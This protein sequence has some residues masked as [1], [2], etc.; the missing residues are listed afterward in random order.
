VGDASRELADGSSK[1]S[2]AVEET[3]S[4]LEEM[5][6]MTAQNAE[7]ASHANKLMMETKQ[8]VEQANQS[9]QSVTASMKEISNASEQTQKIIKTID[10]VAFQTNLLAL[11]AAVE[12]ARAGEA[13]A[14]FAVVAEEVRNLARRTAESAKDTAALIE[15]TVKKVKEGA[16]LVERTNSEFGLV[17]GT[18]SKAGG[19]VGE[20]AA[21]SREQSMGI[22]QINRAVAEMNQIIQS[23]AASAEESSSASLDLNSRVQDLHKFIRGLNE[24]IG[25]SFKEDTKTMKQGGS[26]G[27]GLFGSLPARANKGSGSFTPE[28]EISPDQKQELSEKAKEQEAHELQAKYLHTF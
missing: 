6:A 16:V 10:E 23:N 2:A 15:S 21:A 25:G 19:L 12:A 1:Q 26:K 9:M 4:S 8:T 7:N 3:S 14:G 5:A 27:G 17:K 13:G 18:S 22:E 20:I 24:L 11:N 28:C